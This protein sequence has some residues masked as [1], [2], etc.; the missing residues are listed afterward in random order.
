MK[1]AIA[2]SGLGH[3]A[4]GIETWAQTTAE[5]LHAKG[6]NVT[7]FSG[8]PVVGATVPVD[9]VWCLPR[10]HRMNRFLV[11]VLSK[12]GG[13]RF[14]W[15]SSYQTE[16]TLFAAGLQ[17]L[18]R[19]GRYDIVHLQDPWLAALLQ[20][21][22]DRGHHET[23][24]ILAHGTEETLSF[25]QS[26]R[27]LQELSPPYYERHAGDT[28]TGYLRFMIPNFVDVNVFKPIDRAQARALLGLQQDAF[29]VLSVGALNADR[30]RMDKVAGEFSLAAGTSMVLVLAGAAD[31]D[32]S[33][34]LVRDISSHLGSRC[35]IMTDVPYGAMPGVYA[36][37]DVF[38]LGSTAEIF[39]IAFL[40]A[41]SCGIP[42]IGH[43][44][45]VTQWVIGDGGMC[46]DMA[47]D[48]TLADAIRAACDPGWRLAK[49]AAA[50]ERAVSLF[51]HHVVVGQMIEM[52]KM[53]MENRGEIPKK[54]KCM[55]L[56]AFISQCL[57]HS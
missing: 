34:A 1:I 29:I 49:G 50:R 38:V 22:Y 53:V 45:P 25:L 48:G 21:G 14:G 24:V 57:V 44:Y 10:R 33:R 17:R 2:S 52:Y 5:A 54:K 19:R 43:A 8:A 3:V 23:A 56:G 18:L 37:A 7:L 27:Y 35:R 39:G 30:K 32:A 16:Q 9:V 26:I 4:R 6:V 13:W 46:V 20:R 47:K 15:G 36:A 40:E 11:A 41:M 12:L 55:V 28:R 42:C 31:N 51:S